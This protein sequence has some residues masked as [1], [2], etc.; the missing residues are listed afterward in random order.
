MISNENNL[1]NNKMY[2]K[3][4]PNARQVYRN[5]TMSALWNFGWMKTLDKISGKILEVE[6]EYL[7]SDQYNTVAIE[8]VSENGLRVM[9]ELVDE[10]INDKRKGKARCG[11]CGTT[12]DATKPCSK[13]EKTEYLEKF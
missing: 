6:T 11:W 3:I 8:G 4:K 10:V 7:F 1:D 2:I 13:C 5:N 12:T 9:E